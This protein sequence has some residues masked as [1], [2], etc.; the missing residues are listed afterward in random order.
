MKN[1]NI[2]LKYKLI[3]I[4]PFVLFLLFYGIIYMDKSNNIFVGDPFGKGTDRYWGTDV[5]V[6]DVQNFEFNNKKFN[7]VLSTKQGDENY[8][9]L[10]VYEEKLGGL[11]YKCIRASEQ[12]ESEALISF[13]KVILEN[14]KTFTIAYGDNRDLKVKSCEIGIVDNHFSDYDIRFQLPEKR[15]FIKVFDGTFNGLITATLQDGSTNV[16]YFID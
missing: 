13:S 8:K 2:S 3:L 11:Y 16:D 9:Y 5:R 15:F 7:I 6:E 4:A 10:N 1:Y 12:G 14:N